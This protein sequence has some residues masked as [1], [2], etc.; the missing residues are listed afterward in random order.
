MFS[1]SGWRQRRHAAVLRIAGILLITIQ[2]NSD[3]EL[4]LCFVCEIPLCTSTK[5]VV[6]HPFRRV[7]SPLSALLL[8][9]LLLKLLQFKTCL[10][11]PVLI[12]AR[13][14]ANP[15]SLF[16]LSGLW[17]LLHAFPLTPVAAL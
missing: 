11:S 4:L 15:F 8:L 14:A 7:R 5:S 13:Q 9:K 16:S 3:E 17:H 1:T 2:V 10:E 12:L 6:H